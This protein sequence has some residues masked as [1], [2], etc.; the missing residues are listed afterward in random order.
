M[1][2]AGPIACEGLDEAIIGGLR[3]RGLRLDDIALLP[4]GKAWLMVEFGADTREEAVDARRGAR[5]RRDH[6]QGDDRRACG[7]SARP[8]PRPPR[9]TSARKGADPVVG[10]EDA[11]VD[12]MRLGDYLREF[13]AL[14]DRYGY[15]TS[16][17][18]HFGDGCIHAR[19]NFDLRTAAG[20]AHW[21][22]LPHRGR[23]PG[24]E[25]RRLALRRARRR[26]GEGRVAADHVRRRS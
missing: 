23:A 19:I 21:R 9:S 2:A 15:R 22:A 11:A 8:A 26:P 7:R 20:L 13:Q 3:E 12:P 16:L 24:G 18:G 14:V 17:Y 5:R 10:W 6:R 25:V 1:L 4:P